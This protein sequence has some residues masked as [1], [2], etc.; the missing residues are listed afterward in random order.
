MS[1]N[2]VKATDDAEAII[3]KI[4]AE[5]PQI[6]GETA[7]LLDLIHAL[8]RECKESDERIS[9][10]EFDVADL[11]GQR[12]DAESEAESLKDRIPDYE[13]IDQAAFRERIGHPMFDT[14]NELYEEMQ[15]A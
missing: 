5:S 3:A 15:R 6:E 4:R 10:L 13:L 7:D 1:D 2:Y 8:D 14:I 9:N 12:D 11:E